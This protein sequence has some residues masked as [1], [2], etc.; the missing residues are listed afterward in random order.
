MSTIGGH[1]KIA[2]IWIVFSDRVTQNLLSLRL[3]PYILGVTQKIHNHVV[4]A[5]VFTELDISTSIFNNLR[6][7]LHLLALGLRRRARCTGISLR[8]TKYQTT[9]R[10]QCNTHIF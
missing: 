2:C 3:S 5:A 6:P 10:K 8:L 4:I 1:V 7:N 9:F